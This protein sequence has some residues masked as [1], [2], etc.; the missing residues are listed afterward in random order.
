MISAIPGQRS[1]VHVWGK[2]IV[3]RENLGLDD[4]EKLQFQED[5][6]LTKEAVRQRDPSKSHWK[7]AHL[8]KI[9]CRTAQRLL[10]DR[11][12]KKCL[13]TR[14]PF[15]SSVNQRKRLKFAKLYHHWTVDQ[16]K[17]EVWSDE[18]PFVLCCQNRS[19]LAS[20][21]ATVFTS[22]F[23]RNFKAPE[24]NYG[25]WMFLMEQ[26]WSISSN[27][28]NIKKRK[29]SSNINLSDDHLHMLV[30]SMPR[31]CRKVIRSCG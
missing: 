19:C 15:V 29:I 27:K 7:T 10:H 22:M 8:P 26:S 21:K 18:S 24:K 1:S 23:A 9:S 14:K 20:S 30:E 31:R 4:R 28:R 25:M 5:R 12:Y 6:F 11:N 16:W 2:E 17:K 13:K 3:E